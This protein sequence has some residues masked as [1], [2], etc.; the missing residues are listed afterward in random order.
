MCS[1]T[2]TC[3][4]RGLSA[5]R[6]TYRSSVILRSFHRYASQAG[7]Y[8]KALASVIV[9]YKK[10]QKIESRLKP[11][12]AFSAV[13]GALSLIMGLKYF[14]RSSPSC[15]VYAILGF[16]LFVLSYNCYI[17]RY[18]ALAGK[19]Y[20]DHVG[21]KI[22]C[23]VKGAL[24]LNKDQKKEVDPIA[25]LNG[26]IEWEMLLEGTITKAA[27]KQVQIQMKSKN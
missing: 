13:A 19:Q 15:V 12:K 27:V 20:F 4:P 26:D 10:V 5:C 18:C 16:D 2:R 25:V 22:T 7:E 21:D 24:G 8:E 3:L 11:I 17:K 23:W 1:W 14:S 6:Y 9:D